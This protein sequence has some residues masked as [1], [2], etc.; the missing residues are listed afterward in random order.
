MGVTAIAKHS[1]AA[2]D[3]FKGGYYSRGVVYGIMAGLDTLSVILDGVSMAFDCIPGVGTAISLVVDVLNTLVDFTNMIIGF[4]VDMVDNRSSEELVKESF[5]S[6][7][8]SSAFQSYIDRQAEAYK[9]QGYD[10]SVYMVDA[11]ALGLEEEG[12]D[13]S[14]IDDTIIRKLS[15]KAVAD[16]TDITLRKAILDDS[17]TGSALYGGLSDDM[18]LAGAGGD[19]LYGLDGDDL[20]FGEAGNDSI[21]GGPGNDYLNGGTSADDLFGGKDDDLIAYEPGIDRIA[22]GGDGADT[23]KISSDFFRQKYNKAQNSTSLRGG[24]KKSKSPEAS[25]LVELYESDRE[26]YV[27]ESSLTGSYFWYL[28]RRGTKC[29]LTDGGHIYSCTKSI[30]GEIG[31]FKKSAYSIDSISSSLAVYNETYNIMVYNGNSK[32]KAIFTFAF[33]RPNSIVNVENVSVRFS[34]DSGSAVDT[35]CQVIGGPNTAVIESS[36]GDNT[37][38]YTGNRNTVV[39]VTLSKSSSWQI[40]KS[41]IGGSGSNTLVL[42]GTNSTAGY[43]LER[44]QIMLLDHD[45]DLVNAN[46]VENEANRGLWFGDEQKVNRGIFVKNMQTIKFSNSQSDN[47]AFRIDCTNLSAGHHFIL[48]SHV[49]GARFYGSAGDDKISITMMSGTNNIIDAYGG[50][51]MLS[52]E[53]CEISADM[54]IDINPIP[55]ARAGSIKGENCEVELKNFSSVRGN[56]RTTFIGGH[57]ENNN[58]LIASGGE[59]TVSSRGGN[60]TLVAMRGRHVLKGGTGSDIFEV[61][62]PLMTEFVIVTV[63]RRERLPVATCMGAVSQAAVL[64]IPVLQNDSPEVKL[65]TAQVVDSRGNRISGKGAVTISSDKRSITFSEL[66]AFDFMDQKLTEIVRIQYVTEGSTAVIEEHTEG[67]ALMLHGFSSKSQLDLEVDSTGDLLWKDSSGRLV[68]TDKYW[69]DLFRAGIRNLDLLFSNF[70]SRFPTIQLNSTDP[71]TNEMSYEQVFDFLSEKLGHLKTSINDFGN[72]LEVTNPT[73]NIVDAKDGGN[74]IYGKSKNVSYI[75]GVGNDIIDLSALGEGTSSDA[76]QTSVQTGEG[77]KVVIVTGNAGPVQINFGV[78]SRKKRSTKILVFQGVDASQ[79]LTSEGL[80]FMTGTS[81]ITLDSPPDMLVFSRDLYMVIDDVDL[82]VTTRRANN[83]SPFFYNRVLNDNL[84]QYGNFRN[85]HEERIFL[86]ITPQTGVLQIKLLDG[87][88]VLHTW[89][90]PIR[91]VFDLE[92]V[93]ISHGCQLEFQFGI[94]LSE[95]VYDAQKIRKLVMDCLRSSERHTVVRDHQDGGEIYGGSGNNVLKATG[96]HQVLN[97][98]RCQS[99]SGKDIVHI[100]SDAEDT[101][102]QL[103]ARGDTL[104]VGQKFIVIEG[105]VADVVTVSRPNGDPIRPTAGS[106]FNAAPF[107]INI[108]TSTVASFDA[109]PTYLFFGCAGEYEIVSDPSTFVQTISTNKYTNRYIVNEEGMVTF[110]ATGF[111]SSELVLQLS[112]FGFQ[113]H[114]R[115]AFETVHSEIVG[116]MVLEYARESNIT[117]GDVAVQIATYIPGGIRFRDRTVSSGEIVSFLHDVL[118]KAETT[119]DSTVG[120]SAGNATKTVEGMLAKNNPSSVYHDILKTCRETFRVTNID[121]E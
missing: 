56:A 99:S 85:T 80:T 60:N 105:I 34:S 114:T 81:T 32:L 13:Y 119:F 70:A 109:V 71:N 86:Q 40:Y 69:G 36:C 31:E 95:G 66:S 47:D 59:C 50:K 58:L 67:N 100:A 91:A 16:A 39:L 87:T 104:V 44:H 79:V 4:F 21:Y 17:S 37:Y 76:S 101:S 5:A 111:E 77:D 112:S 75:S 38:I 106:A 61:Y 72:T 102:V 30:T 52:M 110:L 27:S 26:S 63:T 92:A 48:D 8:K 19:T 64:A 83:P 54:N 115:V 7:L 121:P 46:R 117:K 108:G 107:C 118:N 3:A 93:N 96:S 62:G 41:I 116:W 20:L 53:S 65:N 42:N 33:R 103:I 15:D 68:L 1:M 12:V 78:S 11:K 35:S 2:Q 57:T 6:Y 74:Y 90:I 55:R 97:T 45:I 113:N 120:V 25:E 23:I 43:S 24:R 14:K 82:F 10:L 49:N 84:E 9:E 18:I 88:E 29:Y 94:G 51:N 73:T 89:K 22:D 28:A 98:G